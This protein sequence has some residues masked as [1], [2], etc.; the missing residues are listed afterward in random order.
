MDGF[1]YLKKKVKDFSPENM[2]DISGVSA[3]YVREFSRTYA[4]SERSIIFWGMGISQQV[5]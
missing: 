3:S 1:D 5:H 2:E 4:T